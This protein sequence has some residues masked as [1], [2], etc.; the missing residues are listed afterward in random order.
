[1]EKV[2][3]VTLV[4]LPFDG[5]LNLMSFMM[6][7]KVETEDLSELMMK[8]DDI[9]DGNPR[10]HVLVALI[11]TTLITMHPEIRPEELQ[12]GVREVSKFICE[13]IERS[14]SG[15]EIIALQGTID[16]SISKSKMN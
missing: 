9:L 5:D 11:S 15:Q 13:M 14:E 2:A 10:S 7:S 8:I 16:G 1:L 3:R 6:E 12:S 4:P